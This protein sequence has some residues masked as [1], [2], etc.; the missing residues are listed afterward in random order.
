VYLVRVCSLICCR[1]ISASHRSPFLARSYFHR[2]N[3]HFEAI[4]R[5]SVENDLSL[6]SEKTKIM[7]VYRD[8]GRLP[9]LLPAV[10]VYG[11]TV[12]YSDAILKNL[13]LTK[14]NRFL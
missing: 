14:N 10:P 12:P 9:A 3:V 13:G 5:W 6:N 4:F 7:I 2:L 1:L 8:W 11:R